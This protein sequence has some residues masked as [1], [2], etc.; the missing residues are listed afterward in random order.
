MSLN[1]RI[2]TL[3]ISGGEK[4]YEPI[5]NDTVQARQ[6]A[7]MLLIKQ[8]NADVLC[9]QEVAQYV[10][11]N[12]A[13]HSPLEAINEAGDYTASHYG[14]TVSMEAHL[15]VKKDVMVRGIFNDWWN[16][17][18]GNTIHARYPSPGWGPRKAGVPV[19][20]RSICRP[21]MKAPVTPNR[22]L[23]SSEG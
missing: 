16:W 15:Q 3:N 2:A 13:T 12:G 14:K 20:F 9:L 5:P 1:F 11:A 8:M 18:K 6:D 23:P 22:A 7:L 19:I 10:D 21:P 17:S 4:T